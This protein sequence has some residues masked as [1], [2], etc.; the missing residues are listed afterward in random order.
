MKI[1]VSSEERRAV[2]CLEKNCPW[3]RV[4]ANHRSAGEFREEDGIRP[5]LSLKNGEV[6]CDTIHSKGNSFHPHEEPIYIS[7]DMNLYDMNIFLW[8]QLI[9]VINDYQI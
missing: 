4:C 2:I 9:E 1:K 8:S 7:P 6:F 5:L 3:D